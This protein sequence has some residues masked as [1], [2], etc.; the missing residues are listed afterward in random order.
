MSLATQ[1]PASIIRESQEAANKAALHVNK[2][3]VKEARRKGLT[4]NLRVA[5]HEGMNNKGKKVI[6]PRH[7]GGG[8]YEGVRNPY[9]EGSLESL[10]WYEGQNNRYLV[11]MDNGPLTFIHWGM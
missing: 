11:D 4:D 2:L 10:F 1:R 3:R 5:Y 8:Y 9:H 6:L 7:R